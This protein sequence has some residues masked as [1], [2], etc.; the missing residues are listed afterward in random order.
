MFKGIMSNNSHDPFEIRWGEENKK[1]SSKLNL[2]CQSWDPWEP[3]L[4]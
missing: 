4:P 2:R 1:R 3:K